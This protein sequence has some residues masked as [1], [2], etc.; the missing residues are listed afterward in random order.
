LS[1][2]GSFSVKI[3]GKVVIAKV[4]VTGGT[5]WTTFKTVVVDPVILPKG[6]H[7]LQITSNGGFNLGNMTFAKSTITDIPEEIASNSVLYPNP[8]HDKLFIGNVSNANS[9][10]NIFSIDGKLVLN[11]KGLNTYYDGIDVSILNKSAYI[12]H[13]LNGNQ[14]IVGKF[15]KE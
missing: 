8:V 9:E 3:D 1:A 10:V 4:V 14:T 2:G 11:V 7:K 13:I 6:E 5:N 15:V 12:I